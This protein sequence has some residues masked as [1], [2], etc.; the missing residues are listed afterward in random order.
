MPLDDELLRTVICG[1]QKILHDRYLPT[2]WLGEEVIRENFFMALA[3]KKLCTPKSIAN[4]VQN[5]FEMCIDSLSAKS[6]KN[7]HY[8]LYYETS[9]DYNADLVAILRKHCTLMVTFTCNKVV[10]IIHKNKT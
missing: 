3:D 1:W 8:D 2:S 9:Y 10:F 7:W 6:K 5:I 4:R